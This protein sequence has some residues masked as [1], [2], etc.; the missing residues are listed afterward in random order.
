MGMHLG[1][2][3]FLSPLPLISRPTP[4]DLPM[5]SG[6]I[7]VVIF[8]FVTIV[9]PFLLL[10]AVVRT[11][12]PFFGHSL[13][14]S[15][16][17]LEGQRQQNNL[18]W[19]QTLSNNKPFQPNP[20]CFRHFRSVGKFVPEFRKPWVSSSKLGT[21]WNYLEQIGSN[22]TKGDS[23]MCTAVAYHPFF[24]YLL[25]YYLSNLVPACFWPIY[26]H[27]PHSLFPQ[28]SCL[29]AVG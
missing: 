28:S 26:I 13:E 5:I 21:T 2:V 16:H 12:V 29:L 3:C 10:H 23:G 14:Y 25:P 18:F 1:L 15:Q 9:T 17:L 8:V 11:I 27:S 7:L 4:T 22:L 20:S 19:L 6:C 24:T